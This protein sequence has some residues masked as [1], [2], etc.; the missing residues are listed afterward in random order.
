MP[1]KPFTEEREIKSHYKKDP[2]FVHGLWEKVLSHVPKVHV[3][4]DA[5]IAT[6]G[7][8]GDVWLEY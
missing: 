1:E 6:D 7:V 2:R 5:P 4:D 8:D 3:S